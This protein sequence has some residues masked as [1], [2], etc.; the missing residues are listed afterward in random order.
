MIFSCKNPTNIPPNKASTQFHIVWI[1]VSANF[2]IFPTKISCHFLFPFIFAGGFVKIICKL[3][4][5]GDCLSSWV[6]WHRDQK[7]NALSASIK[8]VFS[9]HRN[10]SPAVKIDNKFNMWINDLIESQLD[11]FG[12]K[13][14]HYS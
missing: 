14:M 8:T 5:F 13:T 1:L 4:H 2:Y 3:T 7:R 9:V 11:G 6:S 12:T 10:N